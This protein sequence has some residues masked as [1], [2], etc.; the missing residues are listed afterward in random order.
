MK[1]KWLV[2]L[3]ALLLLG[4]ANL[5][6][7][8]AVTVAGEALEELYTPQA[9]RRCRALA[10]E[11]AEEILQG[12]ALVPEPECRWRLSLHRARGNEKLLTDRLI[13]SV[14]GI[15]LRDGV[16]LNGQKLGT[17]EDGSALL[18]LLRSSILEQMPASAVSGNISGRVQI[19]PLY[20]RSGSESSYEDMLQRILGMAPVVY[21]DSSGRVV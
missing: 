8:C 9:L 12:R 4:G 5:R 17:V 14:T 2:L 15:R 10:E 1:R 16:F 20:T 19:R 13:R 18:S 11:T 7:V 21:L 3:L 6:P